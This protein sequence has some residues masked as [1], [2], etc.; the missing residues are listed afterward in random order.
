MSKERGHKILKSK[1]I[2]QYAPH[3]VDFEAFCDVHFGGD[4][5]IMPE[6]IVKFMTAEVFTQRRI[7]VIDLEAGYK[8]VVGLR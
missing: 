2:E 7:I 3:L 4:Y 6:K 8:G 1:T 5:M